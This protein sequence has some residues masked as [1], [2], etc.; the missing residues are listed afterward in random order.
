MIITRE[1]LK[2]INNFDYYEGSLIHNRF[3]YKF[4]R[5]RVLPIGN[6]VAFR[7]PMEVTTNL[8]DLEDA[9]EK[10]YIYS[11]DAINFCFEIPNINAWAGVAFQRLYSTI[12]GN[13][14]YDITKLNVAVEGDDI[15]VLFDENN[16]GKASVSIVCEKNGAVLG[17]LGINIDAGK[18]APSFAYSTHMTDEQATQFMEECIRAFYYT[19]NSIFIATTKIIS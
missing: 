7:A 4:F 19:S 13:I 1:I 17:H 18:K 6:I 10:D 9:L 3:A 14:L 8:I 11:E 15:F 16:K 12:V 2:K 5:D